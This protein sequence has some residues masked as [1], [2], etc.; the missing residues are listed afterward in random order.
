MNDFT[1]TSPITVSVPSRGQPFAPAQPLSAQPLPTLS[2]PTAESAVGSEQI[3]FHDLVHQ[4]LVEHGIGSTETE[5]R[6]LVRHLYDDL[7][8][9]VGAELMS[10]LS[11]TKLEEF[12]A[13]LEAGDDDGM[14]EFLAREL[15]RHAEVVH[16]QIERTLSEL[17]EALRRRQLSVVPSGQ[18]SP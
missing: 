9:A 8:S 6:T 7:E 3:P 14:T 13:L 2:P 4:V 17:S 18:S 5:L 1:P 16:R 12:D 11:V 10:Q 15:P